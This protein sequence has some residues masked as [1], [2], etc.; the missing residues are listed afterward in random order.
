MKKNVHVQE[1]KI[2]KLPKWSS[3]F[4]ETELTGNFYL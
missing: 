3:L 1:G 4:A 2:V